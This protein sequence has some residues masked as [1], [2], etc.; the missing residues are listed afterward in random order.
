MAG[1]RIEPAETMEAMRAA[2]ELFAQVWG[3]N[4]EG[5]P[6]SSE[7]LRSLVHAGGLVAVATRESSEAGDDSVVGRGGEVLVG[8]AVLGRA[9][10]GSSYSYLAAAGPGAADRGIGFALKQQ[11]RAWALGESITS[12]RWTFDPLVGRNARF[13]ITKLGARVA[14]YEPA[15]YGQMSDELNG[16]DVADRMVAQWQRDSAEAA[17]AAD[18]SPAE[19]VEPTID[20]L[21]EDGPDGSPALAQT[22]GVCWVR[23]PSDIVA[24]RRDDP[25]QASS[26]RSWTA[27]VFTTSFDEG[28]TATGVSC[29]GWRRLEGA[30]R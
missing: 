3:R 12:M 1:V 25:G 17:A 4:D 23:L 11:Q 20:Q 10:P 5:V 7:L 9:E 2:T 22:S 8:A 29:T 14:I 19:P 18:R 6:L 30:T 26:W 28:Y 24:L 27:P 13:N 16:D 15:F 21:V